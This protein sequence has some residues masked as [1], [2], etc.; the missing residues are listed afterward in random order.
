MD[1]EWIHWSQLIGPN[2]RQWIHPSSEYGLMTWTHTNSYFVV[3]FVSGYKEKHL[4]RIRN[5]KLVRSIQCLFFIH[6]FLILRFLWNWKKKLSKF[7]RI[8]TTETQNFLN[9]FVRKWLNFTRAKPLLQFVCNSCNSELYTCMQPTWDLQRDF[10][11]HL[12]LLHIIRWFYVNILL[13]VLLIL[14]ERVLAHYLYCLLMCKVK[15][16]GK[17]MMGI[18]TP[19]W[20]NYIVLAKFW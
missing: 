13:K 10:S 6:F 7:C 20:G 14:R 11:K 18:R 4:W 17:G 3:V 2:G 8:W 15:P 1:F 12:E 19:P 9:F 16:E 5:F